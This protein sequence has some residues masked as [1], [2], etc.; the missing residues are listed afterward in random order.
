MTAAD[1]YPTLAAG[2]WA[3]GDF[4]RAALAEID[5]LRTDVARLTRRLA[6]ANEA[7]AATHDW[8]NQG[9]RIT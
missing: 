8:I 2:S 6:D 3:D 5:R 7:D 4:A 1:D 9:G